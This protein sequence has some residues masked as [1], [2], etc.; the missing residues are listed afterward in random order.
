M[1][2]NVAV[3]S[4][5]DSNV[6][7]T[8]DQ[9][10]AESQSFDEK[11]DKYLASIKRLSR[12]LPGHDQLLQIPDGTVIL[13]RIDFMEDGSVRSTGRLNWDWD[14][15]D[16]CHTIDMYSWLTADLASIVSRYILVED[17]SFQACHTLGAAFDPQ[18]FIDHLNNQASD[19]KFQQQPK[20]IK[21]NLWNLNKPYLSFR[22]YRPVAR[23]KGSDSQERRKAERRYSQV[24]PKL[25]GVSESDVH[26]GYRINTVRSISNILRTEWDLSLVSTLATTS[27]RVAAI[28]ERASIY[29]T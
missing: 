24:V 19:Q 8:R 27:D 12:I 3:A 17:L 16:V 7:G 9:A 10:V 11:K 14:S 25:I 15:H 18:F 4:V 26:D 23:A 21:W 13:A 2:S 22:W 1:P 6:R 28:E 5:E 20:N 29:P